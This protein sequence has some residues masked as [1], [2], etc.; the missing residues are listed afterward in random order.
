MAEPADQILTIGLSA[1]AGYGGKM[2]QDWWTARRARR[3]ADRELWLEHKQQLYLPLLGAVRELETRLSELADVY[4]GRSALPFTSTS[5]SR[6]FRE[7]YLLSPEEIS[8]L[9]ASD[10]D[11]PRREDWVVQRLRKRMCYELNFATSSLYRTGRYLACAR[12]VH[13]HLSGG[14]STLSPAD[15]EGLD[16]LIADVGAVLQGPTE[17]G[18]FLEQQESI[19]E[20]MVDA[21]GRVLSH[22]DFRRRLLELPGWEQFTALFLFFVSEDDRLDGDD[23]RARFAAKVPHEVRATTGAL[24]RLEARL[25]EICGWSSSRRP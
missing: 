2:A 6:D 24:G 1:V 18:I 22:F 11:Q 13:R 8:D 16:R 21:D 4:G 5:L 19:A 9:L 12:L 25:S 7:L 15:Q 23:A 10:G 14:G 3:Q 17:A 20:M